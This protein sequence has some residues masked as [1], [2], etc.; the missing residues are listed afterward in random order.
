GRGRHERPYEV[1]TSSGKFVLYRSSM[2]IEQLRFHTSS[3]LHFL[4]KGLPLPRLYASKENKPFPDNFY[5]NIGSEYYL[6]Y[7]YLNGTVLNSSDPRSLLNEN[8]LKNATK[9]LARWHWE[10]L[11]F[12][13][14]G[15]QRKEGFY[16]DIEEKEKL[17]SRLREL[18]DDYPQIK[19]TPSAQ[20][21]I[22]DYPIIIGSLN[23]I[24]ENI[25]PEIYDFL[26]D[27][28]KALVIHGDFS[29]YNLIFEGDK[30][31]GIVDFEQLQLNARLWDIAH[32]ILS[33]RLDPRE[34]DMA[35]VETVIGEYEGV[36]RLYRE[37]LIALPDFLRWCVLISLSYFTDYYKLQGHERYETLLRE[38][39]LPRELLGIK[40]MELDKGIF[41]FFLRNISTLKAIDK[42]DWQDFVLRMKR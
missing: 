19:A 32:W 39:G 18:V 34:L 16:M 6:V 5:V 15:K 33:A 13:P 2:N 20:R 35:L 42:H 24:K 36:N 27:K 4:Q 30:I 26:M 9:E 37:E 38:S 22:S 11:S 17:F 31:K 7:A 29:R 1:T 21:F 25:F 12:K 3:L 14:L 8:R 28:D 23:K 41:D 40:L 10:A